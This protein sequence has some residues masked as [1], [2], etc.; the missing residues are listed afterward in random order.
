MALPK[1]NEMPDYEI[2][3]PSTGNKISF[4]PFLTKEQKV[5]LI[6]MES[7]DQKQILNAV[8]NTIRS[9]ASSIDVNK[10]T[11]FD[12]EY[13][14]TQM[15]AKSV[16]ERSNIGIKCKKCEHT[17]EI[18]VD[19][20]KVS[21]DVNNKSNNIIKLNDTWTL[22]M[23]YPNYMSVLHDEKVMNNK[24]TTDS[25][26]AM[27]ANCLDCLKSEDENIKFA[28]ESSDTVNDF[29]DNLNTTQ[30]EQIV[31]F[32]QDMPQLKHD[33]NFTCESC[34]A[35]NNVTLKGMNDFF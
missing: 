13:I 6:A 27:V 9:C 19:L 26:M 33:V 2:A 14:F 30:F 22:V 15:R 25:I 7:Q 12:V 17:N 10:L 5:L 20:E 18:S 34:E 24:S 29:V 8:V 28:D 16:G 35:E 31:K 11:T 1:I 23:K 21:I 32:I 3:I 4:R